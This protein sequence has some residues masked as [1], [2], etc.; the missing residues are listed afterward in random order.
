M[1]D[2][3]RKRRFELPTPS[4][5]R[6]CSTTEPL[7][8]INGPSPEPILGGGA[9]G[10]NRTVDTGIFSAVLYQLSYLGKCPYLN[11]SLEILSRKGVLP[12]GNGVQLFA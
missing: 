3:E 4:L 9:E 6:R 12:P 8:L 1:K 10:Q 11:S 5:A 7:P 2:L